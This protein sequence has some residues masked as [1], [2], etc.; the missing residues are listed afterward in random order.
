MMPKQVISVPMT[1]LIA[2]TPQPFASLA[3]STS[4]PTERVLNGYRCSYIRCITGVI[5]RRGAD[6]QH[7]SPGLDAISG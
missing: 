7:L 2:R 1:G 4:R 6:W 3:P 5:H